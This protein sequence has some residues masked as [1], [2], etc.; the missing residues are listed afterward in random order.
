MHNSK[1]NS[2]LAEEASLGTLASEVSEI[3]RSKLG[4]D[5]WASLS[6]SASSAA[7]S[8]KEERKRARSAAA[9]ADPEAAA[10]RRVKRQASK[11]KGKSQLT[12]PSASLGKGNL[13][14]EAAHA[15]GEALQGQEKKALIRAKHFSCFFILVWDLVER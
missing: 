8:R 7:S 5:A 6:A 11:A 13:R 3:L 1:M 12:A 4:S 15:G 10:R 2:N 9:V 14:S